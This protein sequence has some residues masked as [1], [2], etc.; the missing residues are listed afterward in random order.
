MD[1][2]K[3]NAENKKWVL[4]LGIFL[5]DHE[6][7]DSEWIE[8]KIRDFDAFEERVHKQ[9]K[10]YTYKNLSVHLWGRRIGPEILTHFDGYISKSY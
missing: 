4:Y 6:E 5:I 3:C 9:G 10:I 7:W 1:F 8:D 2:D